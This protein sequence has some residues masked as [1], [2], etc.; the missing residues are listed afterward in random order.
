[1]RLAEAVRYS[2]EAGGKRLRPVLVLWCCEACGGR[3]ADAMPAALAIECIHTFSLIHDDLP[4]LDDDDL[5]R[6]RPANHK[7]FGE[8]TAILAGD[9]L[10]ALAFE[11]LAGEI[12]DPAMAVAMVTELATAAGWE[13]MIGGEAADLEGELVPPS[14]DLVARIHAAKTARLIQAACRLGALAAR[15]NDASFAALSKYG[16]ELGLA[17]QAVDDILDATASPVQ[18]GKRTSKDE[19]AGK[20]TYLRA[21]GMEEGRRIA[22]VSIE[23]AISAL[24]RFAANGGK[25]ASL[26]RYVL[27]RQS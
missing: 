14:A 1:L 25:L 27:E 24:G 5:R 4:A 2:L 18:L 7:V 21:V 16:H 22:A 12:S 23:Q 8:A 20:Q 3:E 9:A 13:G 17:F 6:G 11:I 19:S 26:A 15:A 10:H